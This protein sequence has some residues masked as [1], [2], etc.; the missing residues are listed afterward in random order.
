MCTGKGGK[1]ATHPNVTSV[2]GAED[3]RDNLEKI[4]RCSLVGCTEDLACV[5]TDGCSSGNTVRDS[6]CQCPCWCGRGN[7]TIGRG[8]YQCNCQCHGH[9]SSQMEGTI[10]NIIIIRPPTIETGADTFCIKCSRI[11]IG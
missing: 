4:G 7:N 5:D 11:G 2:S 1:K 8:E 3:L 6:E 10:A 9:V